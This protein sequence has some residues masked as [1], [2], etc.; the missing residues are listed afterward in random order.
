[1]LWSYVTGMLAVAAVAVAWVAVQNGW[2]RS[3]A[4]VATDPDVLA[5]RPGC[6]A[7]ERADACGRRSDSTE[8]EKR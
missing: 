4:S 2:R 1:M 5:G 3:F 8:E 7:C 6:R